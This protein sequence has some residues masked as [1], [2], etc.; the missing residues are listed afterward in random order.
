M[1]RTVRGRMG[2]QYVADLDK[3]YGEQ[4]PVKIGAKG[5]FGQTFVDKKF[6]ISYE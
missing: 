5:K 6:L 3:E 4:G 1:S 2:V